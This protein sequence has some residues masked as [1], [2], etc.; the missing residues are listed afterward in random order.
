[1]N[2][3]ATTC[4][5]I[6][7]PRVAV[8]NAYGHIVQHPARRGAARRA[9]VRLVTLKPGQRAQ[10]LLNSTDTVPSPG[11]PRSYRGVSLRVF[12]PDQATP[13]LKPFRAAFCNLR[14][15]A[16]EPEN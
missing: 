11:C 7:Y 15:G 4:S 16:V 3:G 1:M 8:L 2:V 5:M 13:I 10:F 12:P 6:G 14:V 9:P